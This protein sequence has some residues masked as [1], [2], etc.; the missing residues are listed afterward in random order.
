MKNPWEEID[1]E[2]YESHMRLDSVMQLQAMNA[3]MKKQLEAYPAATAMILGVAGGNG[4]EHIRRGKYHTVYGVDI[5]ADYLRA[6]SERYQELSG[7]LQCLQI[8]LTK[9]ADQLPEAQLLIANL[10][11]EYIGY[12]SFQNAVLQVRP[13]YVSCVIQIDT[14]VQNWVSDSP[15]LHAFDRLDDIHHQMNETEL[16]AVM[17]II[18][19]TCILKDSESLPNGKALLRMDFC[20]NDIAE[21]DENLL[22]QQRR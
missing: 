12:A 3:I 7:V 14:D 5:N 19:Y 8:D 20:K 9:Y 6:V 10:L 4:L 2:I 13:M 16:T 22:Y 21:S 15:Y 11:I 17:E 1:L 18:A